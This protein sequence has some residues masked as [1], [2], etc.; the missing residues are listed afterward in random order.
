MTKQEETIASLNV[1]SKDIY[2]KVGRMMQM[3]LSKRI[4]PKEERSPSGEKQ[5]S[6]GWK[7]LQNQRRKENQDKKS[8][9]RRK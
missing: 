2:Q 5:K 7:R 9:T 3:N 6:P 4:N 8:P 1:I